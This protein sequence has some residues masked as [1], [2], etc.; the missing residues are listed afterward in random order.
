MR[1]FRT[2][3]WIEPV[4]NAT[5]LDVEIREPSTTHAITF[6]QVERG[7]AAATTNPN[8][9]VKKAQLKNLLIQN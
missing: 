2:D 5:V 3:P 1:R 7:L 9:G 6:Q 4:G 8:G